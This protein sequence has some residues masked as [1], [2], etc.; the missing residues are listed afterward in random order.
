MVDLD[1]AVKLTRIARSLG[2]ITHGFF[3]VGLPGDTPETM[4]RSLEY[5]KRM[6]PNFANF[7]ICIPFPGT[8]IYEEI[9]ANGEFLS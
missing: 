9:K 1:K 6:N 4:T 5:A 3:I 2:I 7:S 8:E